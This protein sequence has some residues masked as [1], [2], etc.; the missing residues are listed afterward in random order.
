M[1]EGIVGYC[2]SCGKAL[3]SSAANAAAGALY[4]AE[5]TPV[6]LSGPAA[7]APPPLP[8]AN[9]AMATDSSSPV[10]AFLLGLIPGVGAVYNGQY[11]KGLVHV[12]I[13]GLV[14]T[15]LSNGAAHGFEPLFGLFIGVFYFYLAFE[16]DHTAKAK[17]EGRMA[18]EFSSLFSLNGRASRIPMAAILLIGLGVLF[19][20]SNLDL[21]DLR[22]LMRY[23]PVLLIAL[24]AYLL[25][26]RWSTIAAP[27]ASIESEVRDAN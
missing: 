10:V 16:A 21:L 3:E 9:S 6:M 5:H 23:W 14:I 17:L 4:C 12:L 22:R 20:L 27:K 26:E 19:L 15:I 25:Y 11:A 8:A 18:D 2:R 24:G 7:A 13:L 1:T